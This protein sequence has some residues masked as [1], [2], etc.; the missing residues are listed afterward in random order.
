MVPVISYLLSELSRIGST[1]VSGS[2]SKPTGV[3]VV[4]RGV[5]VESGLSSV[6]LIFILYNAKTPIIIWKVIKNI[7]NPLTPNQLI[8]KVHSIGPPIAPIPKINCNP[9]PAAT[10]FSL[11]TKSLVWAKFNENKGKH[12]PAYNAMEIKNKILLNPNSVAKYIF[13]KDVPD[14]IIAS[15]A[16]IALPKVY[17][18]IINLLSNLSE[19]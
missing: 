14:T 18:V 17:N 12:N 16:N 8:N 1:G 6:F 10:N 4:G 5:N 13:S 11:G 9:P 19:R 3:I 2:N 7:K 15:N